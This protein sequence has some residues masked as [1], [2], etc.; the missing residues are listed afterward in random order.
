MRDVAPAVGGGVR[1]VHVCLGG[2]IVQVDRWLVEA[3][4]YLGPQ[5]LRKDGEPRVRQPGE[6]SPF[7]AAWDRWQKREEVRRARRD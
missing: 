5:V 1:L 3:H 4:P 2:P 7:W 6:R